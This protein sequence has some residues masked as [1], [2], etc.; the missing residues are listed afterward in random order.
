MRTLLRHTSLLFTCLAGA[1]AAPLAG[2]G[3]TVTTIDNGDGGVGP[4]AAGDAPANADGGNDGGAGDAGSDAPSLDAGPIPFKPSNLGDALA[5]VDFSK[6]VDIDVT[7]SGEEVNADCGSQP[8]SGCVSLKVT[9][10]DQSTID[11]YVARSWKVE[12]AALL[13]VSGSLPAVIVATTTIEVLGRIDASAIGSTPVAGGFAPQGTAKGMGPGGGGP[14]S[15]QLP[16]PGVGGGGGSFCGPGGTGG[17]V[18]ASQGM[19]GSVYGNASI[20]P[21]AGGSAGGSGTTFGGAGGG[22]F[23]LV[24]GTSIT[25]ESAGVLSAGGGGGGPGGAWSAAQG[26]AGGGSGGSILI[27]APLVTVAG[28]VA[29]N[30]GGGGGGASPTMYGADAT[31]DGKAALGGNGA[32]TG[33]GGNGAAAATVAGAAGAAGDDSNVPGGGGGGAGYVRINTQSGSATI[34]GTLSPAAGSSCTTQGMIQR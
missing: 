7:T 3:C 15:D 11:V 33:A 4:D 30:G 1:A 10:P 19:S 16:P 26:S 23:Q 28:T 34:T 8:N 5:M 17:M 32:T 20:I 24:A 13:H 21:L 14:A 29:V 25:I 6:L 27:E 2:A 18:T 12:P 31:P 9:Q 22:A